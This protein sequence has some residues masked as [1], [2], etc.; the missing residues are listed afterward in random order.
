ML[1]LSY[2][3][4]THLRGTFCNIYSAVQSLAHH[5]NLHSALAAVL[6]HSLDMLPCQSC[7]HVESVVCT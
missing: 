3:L 7:M 2:N 1:L 4:H 5:P 6:L